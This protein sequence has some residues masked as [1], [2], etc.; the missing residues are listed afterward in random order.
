[1]RRWIDKYPAPLSDSALVDQ[2]LDL[3]RENWFEN[4]GN[5][6]CGCELKARAVAEYWLKH[7]SHGE[8]YNDHIIIYLQKK[9]GSF[10][11]CFET[12]EAEN[13]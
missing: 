10:I 8:D 11:E 6:L 3:H 9:W 2:W 13:G 4:E 5:G 1:V 12:E 7:G